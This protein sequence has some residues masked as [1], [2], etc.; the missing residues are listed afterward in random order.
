MAGADT[1]ETRPEDPR[2]L[3]PDDIM[4]GLGDGVVAL[5]RD[6]RVGY[7]NSAAAT[8]LGVDVT[9]GEAS[10]WEEILANNHWLAVL[11]DRGHRELPI[12]PDYVG[13]VLPTAKDEAVKVF[14][15]DTDG[16]DGVQLL[17][18]S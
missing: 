15:Q 8:I 17:K 13:R 7:A 3:T 16:R 4:S 18:P 14:L 6:G 1:R 12:H 2:A 5:G 9:T 11:V 10:V